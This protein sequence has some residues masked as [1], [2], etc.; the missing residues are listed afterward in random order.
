LYSW[1]ETYLSRMSRIEKLAILGV[2]AFDPSHREN[3]EFDSPL[4]LIVGTNGSGKTTVIE[5]LRY[6]TTGE[7][8]PNAKTHGAWIH[9]PKV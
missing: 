9:D 8:P 2:R 3:L 4:T 6:A 7:L 1:A 5:C